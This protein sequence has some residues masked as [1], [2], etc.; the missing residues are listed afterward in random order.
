MTTAVRN[1]RVPDEVA[2]LIGEERAAELVAGPYPD[3]VRC[4]WC[5]SEP[6]LVD[7]AGPLVAGA[8]VHAGAVRIW[9][10][11]QGCGPE[12][13][14]WRDAPLHE[15][16]ER[17]VHSIVGM[18]RSPLGVWWPY[19]VVELS[20]A[21]IAPVGRDGAETVDLA[22]D[23]LAGLGLVPVDDV[24]AQ[25]PTADGWRVALPTPGDRGG[26]FG[27]NGLALIEPLSS[28]PPPWPAAVAARGGRCGL[29]VAS[30]FGLMGL[31]AQGEVLMQALA[32]AMRA[33]RVVGATVAVQTP[34]GAS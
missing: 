14:F 11:H 18:I 32:G 7:R 31:T 2:A 24:F 25:P 23:A 27:P 30:R 20:S 10:A 15:P 8:D 22:L 9:F 17:I 21:L 28:V 3:L 4:H 6:Q 1:L 19:V 26:V 16:A 33:G 29:Y 5:R 13:A 12:G 34:G